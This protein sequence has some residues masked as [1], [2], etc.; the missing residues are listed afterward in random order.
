MELATPT[1]TTPQSGYFTDSGKP[2]FQFPFPQLTS[3]QSHEQVETSREA[4]RE[5]DVEQDVAADTTEIATPTFTTPHSGFFTDVGKPHFT[6]PVPQAMP[7]QSHDQAEV[8]SEAPRELVEQDAADS[9]EL[10]T[11]TFTTP[12]CGFF[13]D[14]GK[15]HF[16]F[17]LPQAMPARSQDQAETQREIALT[18]EVPENLP[19]L[20]AFDEEETAA[21]NDNDVN[22]FEESQ[23][24]EVPREALSVEP[25]TP[26]TE[27]VAPSTSTK[28]QKR[29]KDK[30]KRASVQLSEPA[31][32][33]LPAETAVATPMDDAV[34][35]W[36]NQLT[37][38]APE[39]AVVTD[40]PVAR[41]LDVEDTP[42]DDAVQSPEEQLASDITKE[43]DLVDEPG[44]AD[45]EANSPVTTQD[46]VVP[47]AH[48]EKA[49][50]EP[51]QE[52][53]PLEEPSTAGPADMSAP[54]EEIALA[55]SSKKKGK[56]GKK[57]KRG[58]MQQDT[59]VDT[60][61][62]T[63]VVER[64]MS[65]VLPESSLTREEPVADEII[66][67][68]IPTEKDKEADPLQTVLETTTEPVLSTEDIVAEPLTFPF[69]L[70]AE[71]ES[72][73][74]DVPPT[75]SSPSREVSET[76]PEPIEEE[77]IYTKKSKKGKK[78]KKKSISQVP[79][80]DLEDTP[81]NT[82]T[83][84]AEPSTEPVA[85]PVEEPI[86]SSEPVVA[87][88]ESSELTRDLEPSTTELEPTVH[89][90]QNV[91]SK[92]HL[93]KRPELEQPSE[94]TQLDATDDVQTLPA[95]HRRQSNHRARGGRPG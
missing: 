38:E 82:A 12:H 48:S 75:P 70:V 25:S 22:T 21:L 66:S 30:K 57:S 41:E 6:F 33:E 36:G 53:L 71:P 39:P 58:S 5:L 60:E 16:T 18:D 59:S 15:P 10:A 92:R 80:L 4:P 78:N 87:P 7:A 31:E 68:D 50:A 29:K 2:H 73:L 23:P 85:E 47:E 51:A 89:E 69:D 84:T 27:D 62:S 19:A 67:A 81:A 77:Q 72:T 94:S 86:A 9:T 63:P 88:E 11:P 37:T 8:P 40:E 49:T 43:M 76:L 83:S 52:S 54:V 17:P 79:Q 56:K 55:T 74:Q 61:P 24:V 93:S 3:A 26:I 14:G 90:P 13:T 34:E 65:D 44:V 64:E 45:P 95:S 46:E 32:R 42:M 28:K 1:F 91:P 35:A 20:P